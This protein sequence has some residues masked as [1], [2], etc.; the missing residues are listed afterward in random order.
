MAINDAA[1]AWGKPAE[2]LLTP[3][4]LERSAASICTNIGIAGAATPAVA[5]VEGGSMPF[6]M[7]V[8]AYSLANAGIAGLPNVG[9]G[10]LISPSA[11][12]AI[13]SA[14]DIE[15][16]DND[17]RDAAALMEHIET[18]RIPCPRL[19]GATFS[20]GVGGFAGTFCIG[21]HVDLTQSVDI[22]NGNAHFL[23][24]VCF[25]SISQW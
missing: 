24:S 18:D 16:A 4:V 19:C 17:A 12:S 20:P 13:G 3:A 15:Q 10:D 7:D 25:S 22:L 23:A 2:S 1:R 21:C 9:L 14:E 11:V 5:A 6:D 8:P